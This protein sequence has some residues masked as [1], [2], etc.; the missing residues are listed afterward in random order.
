MFL[1]LFLSI[2]M[3]SQKQD[4][5]EVLEQYNKYFGEAKYSKI[6]N[7]F[8]Y[9]ASFNLSDKTITASTKFKLKLIYKKLRGNLPDYYSYSK[10]DKIDIQLIDDNIA[11][12]NASFSRYNNYDIAF[13]SGSA[14]Y[15]LRFKDGKWKIFSLTPYENIEIL[16]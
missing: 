4:I 9:P 8:D 6:V 12:V 15:H 10:W 1:I 5:I 14:Q 2:A 13:Y 16:N 11:I 3:T 7:S